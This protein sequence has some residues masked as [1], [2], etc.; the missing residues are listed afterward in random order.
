MSITPALQ[1]PLLASAQAQKHVTHNEALMRLDALVQLS[2]ISDSLSTPPVSPAEGDAYVIP[3]GANGVWTGKTGQIAL[4]QDGGWLFIIPRQG[5]RIWIANAAALRVFHNSAWTAAQAE[6]MPRLGVNMQANDTRRLSVTSDQTL[7]TA[8]TTSH[9]LTV[10]KT[11]PADTATLVLQSGFSGRAEFGLPG[12]DDFHIKVSADGNVWREAMVVDRNSGRVVM[13]LTNPSQCRN[14]LINGAFQFNQRQFAGGAL[15]AGIYGY[16][17]WKAG[18]GGANVTVAGGVVTIS[19]GKL[20]QVVD[21]SIFSLA[22]LANAQ[23]TL[24]M[25]DLSGGALLFEA[26]SQSATITA[27]AGRRG[28]TVTLPAGA[29]GPVTVAISP[30]G[31]AISFARV[32]LEIGAQPTAWS[33]PSAPQELALC[34]HF[35]CE[36]PA[37]YLAAGTLYDAYADNANALAPLVIPFPATMRTAPALSTAGTF[38]PTNILVADQPFVTQLHRHCAIIRPRGTAVGRRTVTCSAGATL[39]FSAEL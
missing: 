33:E 37:E 14:L 13:P 28:G 3:A 32:K 4:W 27:G 17:R 12:D 6:S 23:V 20:Q 36:L 31:A 15:A 11:A 1:L 25:E 9:R 30:T 22:T 19:S 18:P 29:T 7:L 8:A 26:A 2:A 34:Q 35:Y 39:K 24:S 16:D 5:W 38:T 21:S 10:N